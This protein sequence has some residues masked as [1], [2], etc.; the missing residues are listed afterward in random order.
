MKYKNIHIKAVLFD[1]DGTLTKPG[2]LNLAVFKE[3]IGCPLDQP[4]FEF[5]KA[6]SNHNERDKAFRELERFEIEGASYSEPNEGAEDL[7]LHLKSKGIRIGILSRNSRQSI[8]KAFKKFKM[9]N[10]SCFDLI[11]SRDDPVEMK[12]SPEG[13]VSAAKAFNVPVKNIMIVG[14]FIFDI[15]A[16][17]SAGAITVLLENGSPPLTLAVDSDYSISTLDELPKIIRWN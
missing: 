5:I 9:I 6:I 10:P 17:Q 13:V 14:D 12:P 4:V 2:C 7:I 16:G 11:L 8:E 1:F 15:Q 3:R